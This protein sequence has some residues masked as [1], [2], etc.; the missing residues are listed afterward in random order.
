M[1]AEY[2]YLYTIINYV[3]VIYICKIV[4]G[5]MLRRDFFLSTI[6]LIDMTKRL[7]FYLYFL[8]NLDAKKDNFSR[9]SFNI[10][11]RRMRNSITYR[12]QKKGI[13]R[14]DNIL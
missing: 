1:S 11:H 5:K 10:M 14:F 8:N 6:V 12:I 2:I 4:V 7:K 3:Y 13:D 9:F